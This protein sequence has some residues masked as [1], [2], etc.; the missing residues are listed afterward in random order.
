MTQSAH[1]DKPQWVRK[2]YFGRA[3]AFYRDTI[4]WYEIGGGIWLS[5]MKEGELWGGKMKGFTFRFYFWLPFYW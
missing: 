5:A 4:G 3:S 1:S 2:F